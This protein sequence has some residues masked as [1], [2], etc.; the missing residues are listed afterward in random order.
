MQPVDMAAAATFNALYSDLGLRVA[1]RAS[2]PA[3]RATS[4]FAT[5][6]Q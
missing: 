5:P 2:R 4:F 6:P 3:W 1:N